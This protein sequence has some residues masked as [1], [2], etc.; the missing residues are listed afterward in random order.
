MEGWVFESQSR[1]TK[2][3]KQV[4]TACSATNVIVTGPRRWLD[5][6]VP[7]HGRCSLLKDLHCVMDVSAEY[8]SNIGNGDVY[9]RKIPN[10]QTNRG[11]NCNWATGVV[12]METFYN[13]VYFTFSG[14]SLDSIT[15]F[16]ISVWL[17]EQL[18]NLLNEKSWKAP[19]QGTSW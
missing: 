15:C 19:F 11:E 18:G 6:D 14:G 2:S 13:M 12:S 8:R 1:Q 10:K 16:A 9:I 4:V 17:N 5:K 3:F 7:C